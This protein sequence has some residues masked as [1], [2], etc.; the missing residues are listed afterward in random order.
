[1]KSYHHFSVEDF[2]WDDAFR[3]W[4][5]R[6]TREDHLVWEQWLEENPEKANLILQ[7]RELVGALGP[8]GVDLPVPEKNEAIGKIMGRFDAYAVNDESRTHKLFS[9]RSRW[10][11]AA[12]LVLLFGAAWLFINYNARKTINYDRLISMATV[13]LHEVRNTG[14]KPMTVSLSDGSSVTLDPGSKMSYPTRFLDS[15]REVYLS[16]SAFFDITKNPERPFYVYA[17]EVVTKVL[18]TRFQ[19]R[20]F[21]HEQ[22]VSVAV[23]TGR[24]SVFTREAEQPEELASGTELSGMLIEPNQQITVA[25]R[26]AKMTKTLVPNPEPIIAGTTGQNLD[27]DDFPISEILKTLQKAY[28]IEIIFDEN[29]MKDCPVTARLSDLSL[30]EKLDLVCNAVGAS[31]QVIDGRIVVTGKGCAAM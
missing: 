3:N 7:A 10:M 4:V 2:F 31:Y 21:T 20:S 15:K 1:M 14:N 25:R 27:F 13:Q 16:G 8:A 24:V 29:S 18:G 17:D 19:V 30:Y 28:G 5:L 11:A 6:P 26:T 9:L 12:S 23:K 22:E